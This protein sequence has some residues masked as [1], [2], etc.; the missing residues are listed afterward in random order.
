MT[1]PLGAEGLFDRMSDGFEDSINFEKNSR[2]YKPT[3]AHHPL[4]DQS[5]IDYYKTRTRETAGDLKFPGL[6]DN[7]S[8][9]A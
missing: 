6:F 9:P 5:L 7:K 8:T 3:L 1:S 2:F 4:P